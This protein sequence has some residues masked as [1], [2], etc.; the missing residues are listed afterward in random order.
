MMQKLFSGNMPDRWDM[1]FA[2]NL[3]RKSSERCPVDM[4]CRKAG[5]MLLMSTTWLRDV[6]RYGL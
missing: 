6:W 2:F 4:R 5:Y 3:L 1:I